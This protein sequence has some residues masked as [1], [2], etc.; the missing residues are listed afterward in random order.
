MCLCVSCGVKIIM[1]KLVL[2]STYSVCF[3]VSLRGGRDNKLEGKN[4][5]AAR[6]ALW[7]KVC[8]VLIFDKV[9]AV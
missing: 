2:T 6:K 5:G 9:E 3:V 4:H 8:W 1:C 7:I